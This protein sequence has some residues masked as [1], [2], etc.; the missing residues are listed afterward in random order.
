[1]LKLRGLNSHGEPPHKARF[2]ALFKPFDLPGIAITGQHHLVPPLKQRIEYVEE[3]FLG[4]QLLR[5]EL[6]VIDQK[7]IDGTIIVHEVLHRALLK[8]C[9]HI[10]HE[11]LGVQVN[12]GFSRTV[13]LDLVTDGLHEVG[14]SK[15]HPS[16]QKQRVIRL[17]R[18][19]SHLLSCRLGHL[20]GPTHHKGL[21]G[22]IR[23]QVVGTRRCAAPCLPR[24]HPRF[25]RC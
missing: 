16:V 9:H 1:M 12:H 2:Q 14:L 22:E 13:P 18:I 21:K 8:R 20:I 10:L 5:E 3:L 6:N 19:L 25:L 24:R 4:P 17:A 23:V 11:A 7:R 15:P